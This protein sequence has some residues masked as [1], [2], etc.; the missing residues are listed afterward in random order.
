VPWLLAIATT[1]VLIYSGVLGRIIA[2]A[3]VVFYA[4]AWAGIPPTTYPQ[5]AL[6]Y[7]AAMIVGILL[8]K[9]IGVLLRKKAGIPQREMPD[10]A[11]L[12]GSVL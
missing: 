6:P 8:L 1:G 12:D 2:A 3:W 4:L 10:K 9:G 11:S 5:Q 7:F